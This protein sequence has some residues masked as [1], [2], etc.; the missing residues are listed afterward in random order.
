MLEKIAAPLRRLFDCPACHR[1]R[2]RLAPVLRHF[3]GPRHH[4]FELVFM[5]VLFALVVYQAMPLGKPFTDG[6]L[7]L[8]DTVAPG[9]LRAILIDKKKNEALRPPFLPISQMLPNSELAMDFPGQPKPVG[10]A[11]AMDLTFFS[12]PAVVRALPWIVIPCLLLYAA[13]VGLPVVLPILTFV[14][15]G[16][17]TLYD[18]QGFIHHGYQMLSLVLVAQTVVVLTHT[19]RGDWRATF[20]LRRA[21]PIDGRTVWDWM[22]RYSQWMIIGCYVIA[23]VVKPIRSDGEWFAKSKYIGLSVVKTHRQNY[24]GNLDEE[25]NIPEPRVAK[26]MLE[27]HPHL[28]RIFLTAGVMLEI[29]AFLALYNRFTALAIGFLLVVFHFINDHIMGLYFYVNEKL[30]WIFLVNLPFWIWWL[31]LRR[32]R[33]GQEQEVGEAVPEPEIE[34]AAA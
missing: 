3:D 4:R 18:S 29:F 6:A 13:G 7:R 26:I 12:K 2:R 32:R 11:K 31:F 23:G 16:S 25:W 1:V 28:T 22:I 21:E 33:L 24:Y 15:V 34:A 17:R 8:A 27:E 10:L 20:G 9:K 5:R 19:L 30:D 14:N